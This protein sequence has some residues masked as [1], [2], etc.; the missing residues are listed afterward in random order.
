MSA[1]RGRSLAATAGSSVR[2]A[3]IRASTPSATRTRVNDWLSS[4]PSAVRSRRY[5]A[6]TSARC[7]ASVAAMVSA[8]TFGL[9]SMSPPTQLPKPSIGGKS[10]ASP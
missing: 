6:S 1:W 5:A 9:P 4:S 2:Y 10:G 7:A 8:P 3:S